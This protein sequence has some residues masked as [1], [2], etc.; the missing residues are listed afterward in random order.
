MA[1]VPSHCGI[2]HAVPRASRTAE[3][4]KTRPPLVDRASA[5]AISFDHL[6]ATD[7]RRFEASHTGNQLQARAHHIRLP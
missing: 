4:G 2:S 1:K 6:A 3:Q 7:W 5:T